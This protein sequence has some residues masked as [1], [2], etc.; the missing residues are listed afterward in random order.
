[1][2]RRK[3]ISYADILIAETEKETEE[4]LKLFVSE[5]PTDIPAYLKLGDIMRE[6]GNPESAVKIHK[7]LLVRPDTELKKRIYRSLI[8]DYTKLG[9]RDELLS[10]TMKLVALDTK[11]VTSYEILSSIYEDL[12]LWEKAIEIRRRILNLKKER[13]M[14]SLAPLWAFLGKK[15]YSKGKTEDGIKRFNRALKLDRKCVP[16]ILFLGD[17]YY[18][19]KQIDKAI[20][21]WKRIMDDSPDFAFLVFDRLEK[22]YFSK[23]AYGDVI[24]RYESFVQKNPE[25]S[26]ALVS[27]SG[28]YT[29]IGN[30]EKAIEMLSRA[31]EITPYNM[32]A[33]KALI[34]LYHTT[35]RYDALKTEALKILDMESV[36]PYRCSSCGARFEEFRFRCPK[37]KKWM[38]I[39]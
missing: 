17:V 19:K 34:E 23:K 12:E 10:I 16:A 33:R 6:K 9:D 28:L 2:F 30:S 38:Q 14:S 18:G 1:M 4:K 24:D 8:L 22:A 39:K 5:N 13:D 29:K 21:I 35:G 20:E 26:R 25:N 32:T 7:S 37:C 36:K 3:K 11:N 15:L 31:I 27:L